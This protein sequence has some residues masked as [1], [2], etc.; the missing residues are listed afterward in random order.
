MILSGMDAYVCV[1]ESEGMS[2]ALLEAMAAGV[3]VV[4]TDVGDNAIL[5]R[6]GI[7][8]RIV[9]LGSTEA[10]ASA[11]SALASSDEER[12]RL[13]PP[14]LKCSRALRAPRGVSHCS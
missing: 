4:A 7:E 10:I 6:D 1:S 3:P 9:G 5:V 13:A 11:V 14:R 8:G 2:S 12:R